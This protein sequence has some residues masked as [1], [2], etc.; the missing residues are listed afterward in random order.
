[1][2]KAL[3]RVLGLSAKPERYLSRWRVCSMSNDKHVCRPPSKPIFKKS[4]INQLLIACQAW[5][6]GTIKSVF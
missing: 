1:M 3:E 5:Q 4:L 2:A 6:A